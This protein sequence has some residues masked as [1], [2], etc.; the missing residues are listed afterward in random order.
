MPSTA[1]LRYAFNRGEIG[2]TALARVDREGLRLAAETMTNWAPLPQGPMMLRPGS[3]YLGTTRENRAARLLPFVFSR[4]DTALLELTSGHLRVWVDDELISRPSVTTTVKDSAFATGAGWHLSV[5]PAGG[6]SAVI[7]G[8][9]LRLTATA[10]GSKARARQTVSVPSGSRNKEHALRIS[11]TAGP[12]Y[13]KV[14][15]AAGLDDFVKRTALGSGLHSLAFTPNKTFTVEFEN[16][17]RMQRTVTECAVEGSGTLELSTIWT[18]LADFDKLQF[19]QSGDIVYVAC[20]G[21]KPQKIERRSA[22]SWSVVDYVPKLGPLRAQKDREDGVSLRSSVYEGN[23]KL[24]ASEP[25]FVSEHKGTVFRLFPTGQVRQARIGA[26]DTFGEPIRINGVTQERWFDIVISGTWKGTLQLQYSLDGPD[27]GFI[28]VAPN[29]VSGSAPTFVK[30]GTYPIRDHDR[31]SNTIVWYRVGFKAADY[32]SGVAVVQFGNTG[33]SG[34][35]DLGTSAQAS[36]GAPAFCKVTGIVSDTVANIEVLK[37]F[38]SV[39]K[40]KDWLVGE[41]NVIDGYPSAV[42]LFDGRLWWGGKDRVWG[43]VSDDYENFDHDFTG[44]A[45]PISRSIG[46]GPVDTIS[47][48]LSLARLMVGRG[49]AVSSVRSSNF[50]EP[51]TPT[52]FT[53][54]DAS[55]RGVAQTRPGQIDS[56]GLYIHANGRQLFELG[57]HVE[58]QDYASHDLTQ[59]NLDIGLSGFSRLAI[60][61]S[62][63]VRVY[64]ISGDGN[65]ACLLRDNDGDVQLAAWHRY[66]RTGTYEDVVVLPGNLEDR[67][68]VV[69]NLTTAGSTNKRYIEKFARRDECIGEPQ[70]KCLDSHIVYTGSATKTITGLSHLN[71]MTVRVWG[72]ANSSDDTGRDLGQYVVSSGQITG[73]PISVRVAVVG[74]PYTATFKSA[75]LAYGAGLSIGSIKKIDQIAFVLL[76]THAQ[77]LTFG[78]DLSAM[79]PMPLREDG[80]IV[81]DDYI[82]D[83]YDKKVNMVAG[84]WDSDSRIILRAQSPRPATVA[85]CLLSVDASGKTNSG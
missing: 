14:G 76:H 60:A 66:T 36:I 25:F 3:A 27:T 33:S 85:A 72:A 75:K 38:S 50:D 57:Y 71:G 34:G 16:S 31:Y 82:W 73:L 19:V 2:K 23:G 52:N 42:T 62:P 46:T 84:R 24:T 43:S 12:V 64:I 48:L 26:E 65:M 10:R 9:V 78:Q 4:D 45:G 81:S 8:G 69:T 79:E 41:W 58:T 55:T 21:K 49:I 47:W 56:R 51:L 20:D 40:T 63:D 29:F 22:R 13:V 70:T 15:S 30:N 61:N 35:A 80:S 6:A 74:L 1:D 77:G 5:T 28:D 18:T 44:D 54:K 83:Q 67:V 17:D 11:V 32:N 37:P 7:S 68:Y 39:E 59:F 53:I